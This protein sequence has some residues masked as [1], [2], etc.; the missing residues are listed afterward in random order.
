[1]AIT[2]GFGGTVDLGG[3]A[4][5]GAGSRDVFVA[6]LSSGGS[7]IWSKSFGD[8]GT[9]DANAIAIDAA[10]NVI[11]TGGFGGSLDFGGGPIS[12]TG[13]DMFIAKFGP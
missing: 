10:G 6:K 3:G 8:A 5:T 12:S 1:M 4:L 7:H 11:V 13:N 9:Q 2:G